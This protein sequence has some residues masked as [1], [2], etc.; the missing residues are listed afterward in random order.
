MYRTA[1]DQNVRGFVISRADVAHLMLDVL[2][3]PE[4]FGRAVGVAN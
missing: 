4:T 1:I 2:E 3:R